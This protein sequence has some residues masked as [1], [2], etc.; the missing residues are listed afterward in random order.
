MSSSSSSYLPSEDEVL[1][2]FC[3][4]APIIQDKNQFLHAMREESGLVNLII[5]LRAFSAGIHSAQHT[6]ALNP[7]SD[8]SPSGVETY[9]MSE[10]ELSSY[11]SLYKKTE[12]IVSPYTCKAVDLYFSL[13]VRVYEHVSNNREWL[14]MLSNAADPEHPQLALPGV[15]FPIENAMEEIKKRIK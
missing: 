12:H 15:D 9:I 7:L 8:S 13:G 3:I 10:K 14:E 6:Q 2:L 5:A 11:C 4:K 1:W